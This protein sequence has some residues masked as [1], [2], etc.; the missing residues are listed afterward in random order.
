VADTRTGLDILG[1][2]NSGPAAWYSTEEEHP[3]A[4]TDLPPGAV[5]EELED[6]DDD[7][8]PVVFYEGPRVKAPPPQRFP[9]NDSESEFST[10]YRQFSQ[11]E[12]PKG[13]S[14]YQRKKLEEAYKGGRRNINVKSL[15]GDIRMDRRDV[16]DW[17]KF[18]ATQPDVEPEMKKPPPKEDV[19][20]LSFGE[21]QRQPG[22]DYGKKK[23]KKLTEATLETVYGRF[24][25]PSDEM[26]NSITA[27]HPEMTSKKIKLWFEDRRKM[28]PQH[29]AW[30]N[31]R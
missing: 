24:R 23:L 7:T 13:I 16:L 1:E 11:P 22:G 6:Y 17:L 19:R 3:K 2:F 10:S 20:P 12:K 31:R 21:R 27:L 26:V 8:D 9:S 18:R 25:W 14:S 4:G 28:D 29:K 15:A 30:S 5:L